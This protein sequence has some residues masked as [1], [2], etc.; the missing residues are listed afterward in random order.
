MLDSRSLR[1][2]GRIPAI[3]NLIV[4]VCAFN[5]S[6]DRLS[7]W[8][9]LGR[10]GQRLIEFSK[11]SEHVSAIVQALFKLHAL[12]IAHGDARLPNIVYCGRDGWLWIDLRH[13]A[14]TSVS[15]FV[16]DWKSL[17]SSLGRTFDV[18]ASC[19]SQSRLEDMFEVRDDARVVIDSTRFAAVEES[20][21][22]LFDR[23]AMATPV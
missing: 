4:P 19:I 21:L 10:V 12:G 22:A 6:D 15:G 17:L 1:I 20:I 16:A 14:R 7:A 9:M 11:P 8:A 23:V 3:D 13:S 5:E 2:R 18:D